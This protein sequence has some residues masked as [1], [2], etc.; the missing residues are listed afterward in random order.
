[1]TDAI[2]DV[3]WY[4]YDP[5]RVLYDHEVFDRPPTYEFYS[6]K[7]SR[8]TFERLFGKHVFSGME[9][10]EIDLNYLSLFYYLDVYNF[11][12]ISR[13]FLCHLLKT[14]HD[15]LENLRNKWL[16][17]TD[18]YV[19]DDIIDA[20]LYRFT[21]EFRI[22]CHI[23]NCRLTKKNFL[24]RQLAIALIVLREPPCIPDPIVRP[25]RFAEELSIKRVIF[26]YDAELPKHTLAR[27]LTHTEYN[28]LENHT[29]K[30]LEW[31]IKRLGGLSPLTLENRRTSRDWVSPEQ[32]IADSEEFASHLTEEGWKSHGYLVHDVIA[33]AKAEIEYF[34]NHKGTK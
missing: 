2:N 6:R 14:D 21:E 27:K 3:W 16:F 10:F 12:F 20:A 5:Q 15:G 33:E 34:E 24:T 1:M 29:P 11:W 26:D 9:M 23:D 7:K 32:R 18:V 8:K 17:L 25:D 22:L 31:W 13:D 28:P 4:D 19:R 30:N